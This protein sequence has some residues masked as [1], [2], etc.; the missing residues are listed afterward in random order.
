MKKDLTAIAGKKRLSVGEFG[1]LDHR[2][3][4]N[5]MQSIVHTEVDGRQAVGASSGV[6]GHRHDGASTGTRRAHRALCHH[7]PGLDRGQG[8]I[9]EMDV[10][11]LVRKASGPDGGFGGS[12]RLPAGTGRLLAAP[13]RF[14][15]QL[16]TGCKAL[17]DAYDIE[18]RYLRQGPWTRASARRLGWRQRA[19]L[20][21]MICS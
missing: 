2:D 17:R 14:R 8:Q 9:Q 18:Q 1:L 19:D 10:V 6:S 15:R 20:S 16:S 21:R 3:L 4:D 5:I 13:D 11:D 7:L 12:R